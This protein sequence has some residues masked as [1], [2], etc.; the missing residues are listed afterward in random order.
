MSRDDI[1][2]IA[3]ALA[4]LGQVVC[5]ADPADKADICA[6]LN[7]TLTYQPASDW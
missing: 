6:Q 4:D 7:P 2:A 1:A 5:E 3:A